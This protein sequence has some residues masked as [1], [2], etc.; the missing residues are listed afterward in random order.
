MDINSATKT[1]KIE[2]T[3]PLYK[4]SRSFNHLQRNFF[5]D[6]PTK[7]R[8]EKK[9]EDFVILNGYSRVWISKDTDVFQVLDHVVVDDIAQAEI[10]VI[11]DQKF[12]R[13]PCP[14]LIQKLQDILDICPVI[15]VC[16]NRHYINIDN[17]FHDNTLSDNFNLAIT[18]W[19]KKNLKCDVIDLSLDYQDY[20]TAFTW[21]I[22]DRH[23]LLRHK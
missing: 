3:R 5:V 6:R 1:V 20:G 7:L 18:Q 2:Q 17:S 9:I 23:H 22:P 14:V 12:S 21:A 16:L 19:L 15:Y 10:V 13:Y 11:T 8:R 4:W